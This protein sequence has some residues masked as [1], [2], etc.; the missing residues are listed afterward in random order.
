MKTLGIVT[1]A[2]MAFAILGPAACNGSNPYS[3]G[4]HWG[5]SVSCEEGFLWKNR[6]RHQGSIPLLHSDG[7]QMRCGEKRH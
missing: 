2:A 5:Y 1:V 3:E 6:G 7:T 4:S